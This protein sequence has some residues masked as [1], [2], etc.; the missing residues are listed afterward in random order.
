MS[1]R[2]RETVS[3]SSGAAWDGEIGGRAIGCPRCGSTCGFLDDCAVCLGEVIC[4]RCLFGVRVD[5]D[6]VHSA[7]VLEG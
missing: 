7:F 6:E 4:A 3:R 1:S 2:D 5:G